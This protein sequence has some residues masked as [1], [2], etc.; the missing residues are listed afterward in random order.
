MNKGKRKAATSAKQNPPVIKYHGSFLLSQEDIK[1]DLR[2][3]RATANSPAMP[4]KTTMV[5][6]MVVENQAENVIEAN[7]E[8][9]KDASEPTVEDNHKDE[10]DDDDVILCKVVPP[11]I[12]V[13]SDDSD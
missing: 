2:A 4:K 13:I 9:P 1:H 10:D 3:M 7:T 5:A 12:I 11:E 8:Q 6:D